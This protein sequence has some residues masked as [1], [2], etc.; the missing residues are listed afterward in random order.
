MQLNREAEK[1]N[2]LKERKS[3]KELKN[4]IRAINQLWKI[5]ENIPVDS[6]LEFL[7]EKIKKHAYKGIVIYAEA[8]LWDPI[9]RPHHFL[10]ELGKKGYLC[11]FL[12]HEDTSDVKIEEKYEN[13]YLINGQEKVLSLLKN[14]E[15]IFLVTYFL[16]YLYAK[17]FPN[18]KV[19]LDVVDRLDFFAAYNSYSKKIWGELINNADIVTYSA[20]MLQKFVSKRKDALLL[21]NAATIEDFNIVENHIPEDLKPI[22][23]S[24][25]KIIGYYGAIE[26]WFDFSIIEEISKLG[27]YEV[28]LIGKASIKKEYPNVHYLGQKEYRELKYYA[29]CFDIAMIPFVINDLTNAVSPVK[30]FEYMALRL[31]VLSTKIFEMKQFKNSPVVRFI[32]PD[33]VEEQITSL[34]KLEKT[35]IALE[36]EKIIAENTWAK[37]IDRVEN[38]LQKNFRR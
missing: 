8:V 38:I 26:E 21:P 9:Q 1:M 4:H 16:Q 12:V 28:V 37:R 25:R 14:E 22:L 27:K 31:P 35:E 29:S 20:A 3:V 5:N 17:Q 36:C 2:W 33:N 23:E 10:R 11:L 24:K 18:K 7:Q 34:L 6:N 32:E 15:V 13:V 19:W 30:F